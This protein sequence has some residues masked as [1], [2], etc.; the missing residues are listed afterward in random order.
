M[1]ELRLFQCQDCNR[2]SDIHDIEP[3]VGRIH[4]RVAPGEVLPHGECRECGAVVHEFDES[5]AYTCPRCS[6]AVELIL[7]MMIATGI[8]V[9]GDG[10]NL[11]SAKV[12]DTED[13]MF[14][15][16]KC[17]VGVPS[18]WIFKTLSRKDA[19]SQMAAPVSR[20]SE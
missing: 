17:D 11:A 5:F 3:L 12:L 19:V 7:A 10:W 20:A 1:S 6:E 4:E 13:E 9:S 15:C 2:I 18:E 14:W 8:T 16:R